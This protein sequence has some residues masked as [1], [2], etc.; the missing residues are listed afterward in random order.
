MNLPVIPLPEFLSNYASLNIVHEIFGFVF[1]LAF[2]GSFIKVFLVDTDF[3]QENKKEFW[4]YC[5]AV[6]CVGTVFGGYISAIL[7]L[8]AVFLWLRARQREFAKG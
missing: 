3:H 5:L 8:I 1:Y 7:L 4:D 2:I 6:S